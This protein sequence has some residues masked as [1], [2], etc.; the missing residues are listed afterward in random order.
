[1]PHKAHFIALFVVPEAVFDPLPL[2]AIMLS[3]EATALKFG[4]E[5]TSEVEQQTVIVTSGYN[6]F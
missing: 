2:E 6:L 5:L 1:M 3:T 4:Q